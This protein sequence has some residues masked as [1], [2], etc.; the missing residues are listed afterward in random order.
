MTLS[1]SSMTTYKFFE[2]YH[3][4]AAKEA[5]KVQNLFEQAIEEFLLFAPDHWLKMVD[6]EEL[7]KSVR[8]CMSET[9]GALSAVCGLPP[10]ESLPLVVLENIEAR[11]GVKGWLGTIYTLHGI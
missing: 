6:R 1:T 7:E 3:E 5:D 11:H 4:L 9:L 10:G 2:N 8:H